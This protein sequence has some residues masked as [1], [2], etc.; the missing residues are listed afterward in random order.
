MKQGDNFPTYVLVFFPIYLCNFLNSKQRI[1]E[2]G[3]EGVST[4]MEDAS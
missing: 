1:E 3:G 2:E 4:V